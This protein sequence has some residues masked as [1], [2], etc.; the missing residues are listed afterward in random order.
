IFQAVP[1]DEEVAVDAWNR[2]VG[3][4]EAVTVPMRN[5]AAGDDIW[6]ANWDA[7]RLPERRSF[8]RRGRSFRCAG[9]GRALTCRARLLLLHRLMFA[10]SEAIAPAAE[11]FD[12][13]GADELFEYARKVAS[14]AVS[15]AHAVGYPSNTGGLGKFCQ[16]REHFFACDSFFALRLL[17]RRTL[18][19]HG[20]ECRR[21]ARIHASK[22]TLTR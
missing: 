15:E 12:F 6:I 9:C 4:H 10:S 8:L 3:D 21:E 7:T 1:T 22:R 13:T 5:D 20:Q 19:S 2:G 11:L 17:E 16:E 18:V 14:P